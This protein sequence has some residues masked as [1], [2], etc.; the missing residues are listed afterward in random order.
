MKLRKVVGLDLGSSNSSISHWTPRGPE[1]INVDGQPLLPSVVTIVPAD[2]VG[3]Y[4]SQ[5]FVGL[6]GIEAGK[7]YRDYC[8]RL[9]KRRLRPLFREDPPQFVQG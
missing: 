2:A 7:R 8:F 4:E 6:D 1:V 9:F 5:I 3:P